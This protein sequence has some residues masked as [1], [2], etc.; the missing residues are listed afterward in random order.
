MIWL[1]IEGLALSGYR[2]TLAVSAVQPESAYDRFTRDGTHAE[3]IAMPAPQAR[4]HQLRRSGIDW[5]QLHGR[6]ARHR[7][8]G[9]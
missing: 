4:H 2:A 6:L 3:M 1:P 7:S 8:G 5:R 9:T